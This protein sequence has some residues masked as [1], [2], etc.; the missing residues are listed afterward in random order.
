MEEE[1]NQANCMEHGNEDEHKIEVVGETTNPEGDKTSSEEPPQ[2]E[3]EQK[4]AA[5]QSSEIPHSAE[6]QPEEPKDEDNSERKG[7]LL[8]SIG[9]LLKGANQLVRTLI[10]LAVVALVAW[11]IIAWQQRAKHKKVVR[12]ITQ[13]VVEVKKI[14]EFCTANYYEETVV[15]ATRK[16]F[17][18]SEDL[19]IIA[20]G[21]VR[22]GFDLSK[23]TT[24]LTSDTSIVITLPPP[25]VLDVITNP[26]D[27]ETFQE[28]GHW[29]HK[30]VT[31][32]K[33]LA[34]SMILSHAKADGIM[35]DAEEY[36]IE[37]MTELFRRVG[38]KQVT[39]HVKKPE[40]ARVESGVP[41][42]G[43]ALTVPE[44]QDAAI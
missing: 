23:M 28:D 39:V 35:E 38:M 36:G 25:M 11:G 43:G 12:T 34:R 2:S 6:P 21:T 4:D 1:Y 3:P 44:K 8:T 18:K 9:S 19:A 15:S 30:E 26:S 5:K 42:Q 24:L 27:F 13:T 20:K 22:V 31:T 14:K 33:N 7:N 41:F 40:P 17:M 32:Y 16:K 29:D 37:K 10:I